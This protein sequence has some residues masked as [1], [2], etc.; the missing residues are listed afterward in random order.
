MGY[1]IVVLTF[2]LQTPLKGV[3]GRLEG[4]RRTCV[5]DVYMF[6]SFCGTVNVW[7][8]VWMVL[9]LY[10]LPGKLSEQRIC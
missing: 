8:G 9:N 7:R 6:L 4:F 3:C 1:A 2:S 5:V 10:F